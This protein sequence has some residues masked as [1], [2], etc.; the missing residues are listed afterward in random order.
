MHELLAVGASGAEGAESAA[1]NRILGA[2]A[3]PKD[4]TTLVR[5]MQWCLLFA[6][7]YLLDDPGE[8]ED[9]VATVGWAL[10]QTNAEG[11]PKIRLAGLHE[12]VME[13]DLS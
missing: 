8:I 7:C 6:F 3:A 5:V 11:E 10:F 1:L 2:G 12:S 13:T 9:E 4:V